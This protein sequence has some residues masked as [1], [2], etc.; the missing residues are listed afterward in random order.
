MTVSALKEVGRDVPERFAAPSGTFLFAAD[1][2]TDPERLFS[3]R[4]LDQ[5]SKGWDE[6]LEHLKNFVEG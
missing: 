3:Y 5:I 4:S 6:A 2:R 1:R